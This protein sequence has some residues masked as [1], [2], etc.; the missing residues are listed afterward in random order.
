MG[1]ICYFIFF[2]VDDFFF[3]FFFFDF[4]FFLIGWLVGGWVCRVIQSLFAFA[5]IFLFVVCVFSLSINLYSD[6]NNIDNSE[7]NDG[8]VDNLNN[9]YFTSI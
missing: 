2:S 7:Y 8:N 5:F 6:D 3:F 9:H 4:F 1:D